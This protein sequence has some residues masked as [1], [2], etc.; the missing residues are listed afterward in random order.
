MKGTVSVSRP[1][2]IYSESVARAVEQHQEVYGRM[3]AGVVVHPAE[4][5]RAANAL[6]IL[7]LALPIHT[8]RGCSSEEIWLEVAG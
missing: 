3:P 5:D 2:R 1:R 6:A 7:G 4:V 8:D